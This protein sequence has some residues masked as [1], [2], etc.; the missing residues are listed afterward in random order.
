MDIQSLIFILSIA[1]QSSTAVLLATVGEIFTEKS[2]VLNLGVEGMM[3]MGALSGFAATYYSHNLFGMET[4]FGSTRE[5][6]EAAIS[7]TWRG[8][9]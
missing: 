6:V 2:G 8:H 5:C 1:I 7:G 4:W 9:R 3:L